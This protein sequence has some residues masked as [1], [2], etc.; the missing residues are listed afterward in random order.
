MT[1]DPAETEAMRVIIAPAV[2]DV[3]E[4]PPE[5]RVS[6]V[7]VGVCEADMHVVIIVTK[8]SESLSRRNL[9]NRLDT[10][11]RFIVRLA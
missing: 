5:V 1:V 7:V 6:D 2:I 10:S 3:T 4:F 9:L 11:L 8:K